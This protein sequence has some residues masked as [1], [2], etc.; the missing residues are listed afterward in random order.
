MR[1]K[2]VWELGFW[3]V[4]IGRGRRKKESYIL[5]LRDRKKEFLVFRILRKQN[6]HSK[7]KKVVQESRSNLEGTRKPSKGGKIFNS[8][9]TIR[10]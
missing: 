5:V 6:I 9:Y 10:V 3:V 1:E 7:S 4:K 2:K 8:S